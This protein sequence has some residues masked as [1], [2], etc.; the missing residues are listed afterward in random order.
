MAT[1]QRNLHIF[2]E[3]LGIVSGISLLAI[4]RDI[5]KYATI[6]RLIGLTTLVVDLY[7][8]HTWMEENGYGNYL[9]SN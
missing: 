4:A 8:I 1:E 7:F 2:T 3:L 6:L 9:S 5:P